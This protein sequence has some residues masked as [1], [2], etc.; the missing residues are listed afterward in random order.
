M[1]AVLLLGF[2]S[3][4]GG[5]GCSRPPALE[6][7]PVPSVRPNPRRASVLAIVV[8]F[9]AG[10]FAVPLLAADTAVTGTLT[11]REQVALTP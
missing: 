4:S 9:L 2:G 3:G 1:S 11:F 8:A 10:L 7:K 5:G 6:V